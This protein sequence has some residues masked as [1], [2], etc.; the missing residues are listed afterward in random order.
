VAY[1]EDPEPYCRV[2]EPFTVFGWSTTGAAFP[3]TTKSPDTVLEM[4]VVPPELPWI[5]MEPLLVLFSNSPSGW[6][7]QPCCPS[8]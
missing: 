6:R 4:A 5:E 7:H 8:G 2:A 3:V 1:D